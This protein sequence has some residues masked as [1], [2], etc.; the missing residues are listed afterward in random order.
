MAAAIMSTTTN[1][2][3]TAAR[4][5]DIRVRL[6]VL[7]RMEVPQPSRVQPLP[8]AVPAPCYRHLPAGDEPLLWLADGA[9]WA[10]SLGRQIANCNHRQVS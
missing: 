7:L 8:T 6:A 9:A 5:K 1:A 4:I 10:L 3:R 2:V